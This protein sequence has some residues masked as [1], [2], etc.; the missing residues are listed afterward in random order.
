MLHSAL[1]PAALATC[2]SIH[3]YGSRHLVDWTALA[4]YQGATTSGTF[5]SGRTW[6]RRRELVSRTAR[7]ASRW[8]CRGG[9]S[10]GCQAHASPRCHRASRRRA[11]RAPSRVSSSRQTAAAVGLAVGMPRPA[12]ASAAARFTDYE[13]DVDRP[14]TPLVEARGQRL[15]RAMP[16]S[17]PANH[18]S[19]AEAT[20]GSVIAASV[21]ARHGATRSTP[22]GACTRVRAEVSETVVATSCSAPV[23]IRASGS[24][25]RP[26]NSRPRAY[27][28]RVSAP[29][30]CRRGRA[31]IRPRR[32]GEA[33]RLRRRAPSRTSCRRC[34]PSSG[35]P[36][37]RS[38]SSTRN[39]EARG[40]PVVD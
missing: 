10:S 35:M 31:R 17:S 8:A 23:L 3:V 13:L 40:R 26:A 28:S 2:A 21:A 16:A 27:R 32:L 4:I 39:E 9:C 36:P 1:R 34:I 18:A 37:T 12:I 24:D 14:A 30:R 5:R 38:Q 20:T 19:C 25:V 29:Y 7:D 33:A 6:A 11:A 22:T 15:A